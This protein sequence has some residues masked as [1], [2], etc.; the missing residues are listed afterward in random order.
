LRRLDSYESGLVPFEDWIHELKD[1]AKKYLEIDLTHPQFQLDWP[2]LVRLFTLHNLESKIDI[3]QL[4]KE[5]GDFLDAFE[6]LIVRHSDP[7]N[8]GRRIS[9]EILRS[10]QDDMNNVY[11]QVKSYLNAP[12]SE[13]RLPDPERA[14]EERGLFNM[15]LSGGMAA[16]QVYSTMAGRK[17]VNEFDWEHIHLFWTDERWVAPDHSRSNYGLVAEVLLTR[18]DIPIE[19]IHPIRTNAKTPEIAAICYEE[20]LRSRLT[21]EMGKIPQIDLIFFELGS[22][23]HVASLFSDHEALVEKEKLV[24]AV[25]SDDLYEERVTMTLP[26]INHAEQVLFIAS[27]REKSEILLKV[28]KGSF[29]DY[30]LPAQLVRPHSGYM[31]WFMDDAAATSLEV[32]N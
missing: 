27:G 4:D 9:A 31:Q 24:T 22:S 29:N 2:M 12:L 7:A 14:I 26:L 20:A 13:H 18:V 21:N 30:G 10:A 5:K 16:R 25:R 19:N 11:E 1:K 3:D 17:F 6:T 32:V 28:L 15:A 8:G 23:G